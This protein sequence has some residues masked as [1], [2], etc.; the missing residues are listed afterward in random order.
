MGQR[1]VTILEVLLAAMLLG[2]TAVV[3][4]SAFALGVRA[5]ALAS[6]LQTAASIAEET[7]TGLAAAPCGSSLRTFVPTEVMVRG[8]Q[9]HQD[10]FVTPLGPRLWDLAATVS[11]TQERRQRSVTLRTVRYI[12]A[13]CEFDG[14]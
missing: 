7:L 8:V 13:A 12:S 11:W 3:I 1:G 5:A 14:R 10:A 4:F 9:F 6:G 2:L